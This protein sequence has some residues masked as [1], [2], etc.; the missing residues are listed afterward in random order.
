MDNMLEACSFSLNSTSHGSF[1]LD[2]QELHNDSNF[3][4]ENINY[5]GEISE[6]CDP[7]PALY[8]PD[9]QDAELPFL[10]DQDYFCNASD[11]QQSSI[12][13]SSSSEQYSCKSSDITTPLLE[14]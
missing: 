1:E 5:N 14:N 12:S 2:N 4:L 13:E 9:N 6:N 7:Y 10:G 8:N 3:A 11:R